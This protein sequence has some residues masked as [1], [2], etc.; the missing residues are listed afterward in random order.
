M[1]TAD[2]FPVTTPID[3]MRE[4]CNSRLY[5]L[6][7]KTRIWWCK[8]TRIKLG[9][10]GICAH[11]GDFWGHKLQCHHKTYD[12]LFEERDEDLEA[13]CPPCHREAHR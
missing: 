2:L 10:G 12:R 3:I 7:L 8:A 6:Y 1:T 9:Q 4:I 13:I 5:Q 11:C